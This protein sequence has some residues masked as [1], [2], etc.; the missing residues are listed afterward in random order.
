MVRV[1]LSEASGSSVGFTT[2]LSSTNNRRSNPRGGVRKYYRNRK[3]WVCSECHRSDKVSEWLSFVF[4]LVV[5]VGSVV[6]FSE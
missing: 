6:Y 3:V 1:T 5:I 4:W 2:N